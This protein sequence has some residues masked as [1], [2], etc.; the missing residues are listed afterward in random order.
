ML[1]GTAALYPWTAIIFLLLGWLFS[2]AMSE[3]RLDL[4]HSLLS[5]PFIEGGVCL[6]A[7]E[8]AGPFGHA[9]CLGFCVAMLIAVA[10]GEL[11]GTVQICSSVP[12]AGRDLAGRS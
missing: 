7:P 5:L 12:P 8:S 4:Q 10:S 11:R 1:S 2:G 6:A 9:V 3:C